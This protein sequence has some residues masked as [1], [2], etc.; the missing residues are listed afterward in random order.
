MT[1]G[2]EVWAAGTGTAE[3]VA[4]MDGSAPKAPCASTSSAVNPPHSR[5]AD[6]GNRRLA[7][8]GAAPPHA[9][10][11]NA[12]KGRLRLILRLLS[13]WVANRPVQQDKS[14]PLPKPLPGTG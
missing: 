4:V 2:P 1:V 13:S 14:P 11:R 3:G 5:I 10:E 9:G 7:G 6:F 12:R 8:D